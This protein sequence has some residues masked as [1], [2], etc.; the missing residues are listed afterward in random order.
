[1]TLWTPAKVRFVAR[2]LTLTVRAVWWLVTRT[3]PLVAGSILLAAMLQV[4]PTR[5]APQRAADGIPVAII[6][7]VISA[8][9]WIVK[10]VRTKRRRR[11]EDSW[12]VIDVRTSQLPQPE[13]QPSVPWQEMHARQRRQL[14]QAE[15]QSKWMRVRAEQVPFVH[16]AIGIFLEKAGFAEPHWFGIP[17][18]GV[19]FR[20]Y[21]SRLR[22][23]DRGWLRNLFRPEPMTGLSFLWKREGSDYRLRVHGYGLYCGEAV[24]LAERAIR[25]ELEQPLVQYV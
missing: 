7:L 6:V 22:P 15:H 10:S 14:E 1:M 12:R 21:G 25:D 20:N 19:E 11:L 23:E 18:E 9:W 5:T 8:T 3:G 17:E 13:S 24:T 4:D 2:G 16:T